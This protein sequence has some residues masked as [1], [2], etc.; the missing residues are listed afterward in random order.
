MSLQKQIPPHSLFF[1]D[2]KTSDQ[3]H[4]FN[5]ECCIIHSDRIQ[6]LY[7]SVGRRKY[8][9][10]LQ[11]TSEFRGTQNQGATHSETSDVSD[12]VE[13]MSSETRER[14][15]RGVTR[16]SSKHRLFDRHSTEAMVFR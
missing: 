15:R 7:I 10:C 12:A 3:A 6:S 14:F 4:E 8:L 11:G 2:T 9:F 13:G 5:F 16:Q 1:R